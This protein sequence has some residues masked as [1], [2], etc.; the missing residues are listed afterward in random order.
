MV[1]NKQHMWLKDRDTLF[2]CSVKISCNPGIYWSDFTFLRCDPRAQGITP[3]VFWDRQFVCVCSGI[4]SAAL[5]LPELNDPHKAAALWGADCQERSPVS[6]LRPCEDTALPAS[7]ASRSPVQVLP[8]LSQR[9]CGRVVLPSG[10][11]VLRSL[12]WQL[13][14]R[15]DLHLKAFSHLKQTRM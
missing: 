10:G 13:G 3:P 7:Y 2:W 9:G 1:W 12:G 15:E 5:L 8:E 11:R 14:W 6:P 4:V